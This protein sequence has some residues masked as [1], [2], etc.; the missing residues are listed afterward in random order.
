MD[1]LAAG[2]AEYMDEEAAK[3]SGEKVEPNATEEATSAPCAA[4][5]DA[6][7]ASPP[8]PGRNW[9]DTSCSPSGS[10][11]GSSST[12]WSL[13]LLIV[14]WV[15]YRDIVCQV[16]QLSAVVVTF[17]MIF[18]SLLALPRLSSFYFIFKYS[19]SLF[20]I[21]W[22]TNFLQYLVA[23]SPLFDKQDY[24]KFDFWS[25]PWAGFNALMSPFLL[26]DLNCMPIL[27]GQPDPGKFGSLLS[28][29][30]GSRFWNLYLP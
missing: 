29:W 18:R 15:S 8:P 5:T 9:W 28:H 3:G 30:A 1:E 23:Y 10:I 2:L 7:E 20:A 22:S 16:Y 17:L 12:Y 6:I 27:D 21:T 14:L 24:P 11:S 19:I 4:P 13:V 26:L 25:R